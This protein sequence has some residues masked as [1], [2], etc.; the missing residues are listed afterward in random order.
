M[1]GA[2]APVDQATKIHTTYRLVSLQL[3]KA[4]TAISPT[5]M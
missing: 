5:A 1:V 4:A 2:I 3:A